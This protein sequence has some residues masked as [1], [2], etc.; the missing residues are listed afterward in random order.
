VHVAGRW[1]EKADGDDHQEGTDNAKGD[2]PPA[3]DL[4]H[5]Y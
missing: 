1:R 2:N 5:R 4:L 3:G